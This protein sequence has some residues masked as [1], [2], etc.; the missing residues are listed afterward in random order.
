MWLKQT[1]IEIDDSTAISLTLDCSGIT[2]TS[3]PRDQMTGRRHIPEKRVRG[4]PTGITPSQPSKRQLRSVGQ[5]SSKRKLTYGACNELGVQSA[6]VTRFLPKLE[7]SVFIASSA[8]GWSE[9]E[10]MALTEFLLFHGD[11]LRWMSTK[12]V[13]SGRVPQNFF[14]SGV[15]LNE[16]VSVQFHI[17]SL[18]YLMT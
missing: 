14:Y 8:D 4:T 2:A 7:K 16:Q 15:D 9:A 3:A 6:A 12:Q 17:C 1:P 5:A 18:I 11:G 13:R 10:E